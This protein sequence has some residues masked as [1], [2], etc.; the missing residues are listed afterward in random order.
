MFSYDIAQFGHVFIRLRRPAAGSG[1]KRLLL[2]LAFHTLGLPFWQPRRVIGS[3]RLRRCA[4]PQRKAASGRIAERR[5]KSMAHNA[6]HLISSRPCID[7]PHEGVGRISRRPWAAACQFLYVNR[8]TQEPATI[9]PFA[10]NP[11][12][13]VLATLKVENAGLPPLPP[14]PP[15]HRTLSP[16]LLSSE[17]MDGR[18]PTRGRR[19]A[20]RIAKRCLPS[21]G[22]CAT[23]AIRNEASESSSQNRKRAGFGRG[24]SESEDR[25]VAVGAAKFGR[26]V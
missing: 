13:A 20:A 23:P 16:N 26:A 17:R 12:A 4:P 3:G 25:A 5:H 10:R 24:Q 2:P 15:S 22:A 18:G 7:P 11:F 6:L 14:R 8:S 1:P 21:I 19:V 9:V